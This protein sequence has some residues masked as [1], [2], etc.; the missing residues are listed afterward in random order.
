MHFANHMWHMDL[1]E[2]QLSLKKD[3]SGGWPKLV[4]YIKCIEPVSRKDTTYTNIS[5][6]Y[7]MGYLMILYNI[8]LFSYK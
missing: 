7:A 6:M 8:F 4:H 1:F 5:G 2:Q 3:L